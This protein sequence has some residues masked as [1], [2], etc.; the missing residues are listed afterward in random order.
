M[1]MPFWA[2]IADSFREALDRKIFWVM[3]CI[4][5]LVAAAMFCVSFEGTADGSIEELNVFF[6]AYRVRLSEAAPGTV[7][8]RETI[9]G[10]VVYLVMD[11]VLGG[12]GILLALIATGSFFPSFLER[13]AIDLALSKSL[14]R[15][16]LFLAKYLGSMAF[17]L[18]QAT[19]F[20]GLTFLVVGFR[21]GM[22]MPGYL[23]VIPLMVLLFSYLYCVS[24]WV[25]VRTRS[26]LAAVL[27]SLGAWVVFVGL[28]GLGD[29]FELMPQWKENRT[30]YTVARVAGWVVPKT[31]DITYFAGRWSGA[32]APADV[33]PK[34]RVPTPADRELIDKAGEVDRQRFEQRALPSIGS[35][36]LFEAV[37]VAAAMWTFSRRD[38]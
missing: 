35:S 25:A 1:M 27:V 37:V 15:P 19:V 2:L 8:P 6:G 32:P 18:V 3:L 12:I 34:T 22:W 38:Y 9:I 4:S 30:L 36:L 26:T 13:G 5:I 7:I 16:L 20:V 33:M 28:Q 31:Q 24:A 29:V 11:H 23:L 21:W 14:S 17:V 10:G